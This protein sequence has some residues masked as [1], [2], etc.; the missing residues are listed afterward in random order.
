MKTNPQHSQDIN[1]SLF[2]STVL[3]S[4]CYPQ[5]AEA[6]VFFLPSRRFQSYRGDKM[7]TSQ[8]VMVSEERSDKG[9]WVLR[10]EIAP[11]SKGSFGFKDYCIVTTPKVTLTQEKLNFRHKATY[12]YVFKWSHWDLQRFRHILTN[13][14]MR[15]LFICSQLW[16]LFKRVSTFLLDCT[17]GEKKWTWLGSNP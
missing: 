3:S 10:E 17:Q 6:I 7:H 4:V 15:S 9:F 12:M 14:S 13:G 8:G 16:D 11:R 2:S 1:P 5:A